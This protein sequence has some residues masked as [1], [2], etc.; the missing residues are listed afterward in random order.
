MT[1]LERTRIVLSG[2]IP[3]RV[4]VCLPSFL[5]AARLA[6]H[7]AGD[8][9][10]SGERMAETQLAYWETFRHDIID[11]ENGVAAMAE[12][13]GCIVEYSPT[14]APWVVR[15]AI[16]SLDEIDR[17]PT[18]DP[19][20]SPA[21]AELLKA[22]RIVAGKMG[23]SICVRSQSDQGP[24]SLAAQIVGTETFMLALLD[25]EQTAQIHRLLAY[26]ADRIAR[27]A[28][29]QIAAGA[30]YTLIGDSIAGPDVCSPKIYR[31]FAQPH[32]KR[33]IDTL[34]REGVEA[35]IHICGNATSIAGDIADT[36]TLYVELD[37]K[38]DR[39]RARAATGGRTTIFGA[40]D[41]HGLL[42]HGTP[43][44]VTAAAREDIRLLGQHGRFVLSPGCTMAPETAVPNVHAIV[45]AAR[46]YGRY[47]SSGMIE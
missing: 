26:A 39:A 37:S 29:A 18:V 3:D 46:E 42:V 2:G 41:P 47:S 1:S 43:E 19:L 38:I 16:Q 30:H 4:P 36:G 7:A 8:Y 27:L 13:V 40:L 22:T 9:C 11:I 33:L 28:K 34:R 17:L 32:E 35:G 15:P 24:F 21:L 14:A 12:A 25:P 5:H 44:E 6:G 45:E 20:R 31:T 10:L 23:D